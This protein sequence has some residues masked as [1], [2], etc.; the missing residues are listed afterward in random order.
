M[1][2]YGNVQQLTMVETWH[3]ASPVLCIC[4]GCSLLRFDITPLRDN[5]GCSN[6]SGGRRG[7][8]GIAPRL[9]GGVILVQL[10]PMEAVAA[11]NSA[12][13]WSW[14]RRDDGHWRLSCRGWRPGCANFFSQVVGRERRLGEDGVAVGRR[15]RGRSARRIHP[16]QRAECC[17]GSR[18]FVR[19]GSGYASVRG[20]HC[21]E[22]DCTG[23]SLR[24]TPSCCWGRA[25]SLFS[26]CISRRFS[27][28]VSSSRRAATRSWHAQ[29]NWAQRGVNYAATSDW[30]R[31]VIEMTDGVGA[32]YA[33]DTVGNLREALAAVR[34]GGPWHSSGF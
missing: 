14:D 27:E 23:K 28:H 19:R 11:T 33:V 25:V 1:S 4:R 32:D 16:S 34:L 24:V 12:I 3:N 2:S 6:L 18:A 29:R 15:G 20:C 5:W 21:L 30:P 7:A 8:P 13:R 10:R 26:L 17:P 31:A 22:F 9:D